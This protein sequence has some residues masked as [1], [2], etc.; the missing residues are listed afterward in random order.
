MNNIDIS[1]PIEEYAELYKE[2]KFIGI[3]SSEIQLY[4][5]R[6]QIAEKKLENYNIFWVD[7]ECI[8][9]N[10]DIASCGSLS[11]YP[12]DFFDLTDKYLIKLLDAQ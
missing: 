12:V 2:N 4:S 5:I 9:H 11:D 6:S 7:K 10:I 3:I 1:I 8:P